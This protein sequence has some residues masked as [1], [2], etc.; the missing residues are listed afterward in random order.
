MTRA[1]SFDRASIDVE[2]RTANLSFASAEPVKRYFGTEVLGFG[3]DECDLSRLE[4][5]AALLLNHDTNCQI[6]VVERAWIEGG[7]GMATVRFS[8]SAEAQAI[9]DDVAD[10]IRTKVS[11]G[12]NVNAAREIAKEGDDSTYLISSWQPYEVSIVSVP[13]DDSVGVGRAANAIE[14]EIT[15][16]LLHPMKRNLLLN[17]D[18]AAGGGGSASVVATPVI[19]GNETDV[20]RKRNADTIEILA[21]AER[22]AVPANEVREF[23]TSGKSKSDFAEMVL[24]RTGAKPLPVAKPNE[25]MTRSLGSYSVLRALRQAIDHNGNLTTGLEAEVSQQLRSERRGLAAPSGFLMPEAVMQRT[26]TTGAFATGGAL[27]QTTVDGS[28]YVEYLRN[29]T[30]VDKLGARILSGLQGNLA[31]PRGTSAA[32]AYW[33]PDNGAGTVSDLN[34]GQ[35]ALTPHKLVA[36]SRFTKDLMNQASLDVEGLVRDDLMK[37]TNLAIDLAALAGTGSA[38]QPLGVANIL[39]GDTNTV[40]FSAAATWA[41]ILSFETK[42]A[43]ANADVATMGWVVSP[44]TREKWKTNAKIG[45]TFPNFLWDNGT[46]PGE[47]MVNG[48]RALVTN[49]VGSANTVAEQVL[50]GNWA[51]LIIGRWAGID[52]VVNPYT[53]DATGAIKITLTQW[54]DVAARHGKSF[55]RSTDSGA[56]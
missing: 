44:A 47:G 42:V 32:T 41:K 18:P 24:A 13:A 43:Q 37:Q 51:D 55:C 1:A 3:P 5:G 35:V 25:D 29:K 46:T 7:R 52:V 39:S 16:E 49:Q 11:V 45:S 28:Q 15:V 54:M 9:F 19:T 31:L 22:F 34:L 10:G 12:Y 50:F 26:L 38:G 4:N 6:G 53:D 27:V 17:P 8:K 40:T 33:L 30:V 20:L 21:I 23:I 36:I 2:K 56:Q 14:T 48:Y